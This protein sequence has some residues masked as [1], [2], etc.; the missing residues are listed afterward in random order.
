MLSVDVGTVSC[1]HVLVVVVLRRSRSDAALWRRALAPTRLAV[2][3]A[4]RPARLP[5]LRVS[6][7]CQMEEVT[8]MLRPVE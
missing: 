3:R 7:G 1:F 6:A 4:P 2:L 5:T 8:V